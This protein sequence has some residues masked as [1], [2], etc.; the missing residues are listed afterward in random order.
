MHNELPRLILASQSHARQTM[1]A[2][3]GLIFDAIPA[4]I[5]EGALQQAMQAGG[6]GQHAVAAALAEA[7]ATA[8]AAEDPQALVI[9]GDQL[10]VFDGQILTKATSRV[11]AADKLNRLKGRTHRLVSAA[12]VV[13]GGALLWAATDEAVLT[14]RD[15]DDDFLHAY[16]DVAGV[17]LTRSV[18]AYEFEAAGAWLFERVEGDFFTILG[19]PLL[20]LLGF[21]K[22]R[23]YGP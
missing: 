21:L 9:G 5:D 4:D 13:Q 19:L 20:P 6:A 11:A 15:F 2:R 16:L 10:L 8:L 7:K 18:G 3:A 23:G 1:L 22:S 12:C 17:A 14:M